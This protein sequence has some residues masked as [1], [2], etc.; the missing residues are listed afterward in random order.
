MNLWNENEALQKD[1]RTEMGQGKKLRAKLLEIRTRRQTLQA[2][3]EHERSLYES[4]E[5]DAKVRCRFLGVQC[6][7]G[8]SNNV[9]P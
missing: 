1:R 8:S 6:M 7:F 5:Y 2:E 4:V 9:V 3:I